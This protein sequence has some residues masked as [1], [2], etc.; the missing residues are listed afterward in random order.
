MNNIFIPKEIIIGFQNRN[1]TYT[2]KLAYVIYKDENGKLRKEQSWNSWRDKNIE[3]LI[4]K[5]TPMSGFVLNKKIGGY[6][7]GWNHRQTYVRIYDS[8]EFEFEITVENL[9]YIL[10]NT[11]SI[12]GKG[13]E[14]EFV[15]GWDGKELILIPISSPD[16]KEI[17]EFNKILHNKQIIKAK[18]LII[19]ATYK[20]KQNQTF[21]Y[22]GKFDYYSLYGKKCTGKYHWFY[23]VEKTKFEQIKNISNKLIG[24]I[25]S[26]CHENY[27]NIFYKMEGEVSYSPIDESKHEF[28][29]YTLEEF[30]EKMKDDKYCWGIEFYANKE[31]VRIYSSGRIE[32]LKRYNTLY[33]YG[34][35]EEKYDSLEELYN[36]I[37]PQYMKIYLLNGRLYEQG[38]K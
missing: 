35:R 4:Y 9:L 16:Y 12:K 25:D 34:Y 36:N 22:I 24:V 38:G 31:K 2:G 15:Y 14:G 18:D 6:N 17:T 23:N 37:K 7:T 33:S 27:S 30:K 28:I 13:L 8:R 10:E 5:N 26:N 21:I 1:G 20:T 11:S 29:E 19:G 3:P 32:Y